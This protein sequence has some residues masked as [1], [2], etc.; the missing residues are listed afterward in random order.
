[1]LT[2][3][4][5]F[6]CSV[7]PPDSPEEFRNDNARVNALCCEQFEALLVSTQSKQLKAQIF[8]QYM[9][10]FLAHLRVLVAR[11]DSLMQV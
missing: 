10:R 11:N 3:L 8:L 9:E 7:A 1:M 6:I 2:L 5:R 4:D